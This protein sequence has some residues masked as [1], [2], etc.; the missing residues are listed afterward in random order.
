MSKEDIHRILGEIDHMSRSLM[1]DL[2]EGG[3]SEDRQ[4]QLEIVSAQVS[5]LDW[6]RDLI[7]SSIDS[8]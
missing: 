1:D 4:L 5:I 7:S 3:P 8:K 2:E 6:V